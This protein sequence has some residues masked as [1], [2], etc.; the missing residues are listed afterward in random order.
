MRAILTLLIPGALA[1]TVPAAAGDI[2]ADLLVYRVEES[3]V[4]P[5]FTRYLVTAGHLRMDEGDDAGGYTLYD[6]SAGVIFNVDPEERSVLVID[7]PR[8]L[9]P[10]PLAIELAEETLPADGLAPLDGIAPARYS[11][12]ANGTACE[13]LAAVAGVMQAA[14][15]AL[16]DFDDRL[17]YQHG[18][19]VPGMPDDLVDPC[20]LARHVYAPRRAYRFG[21]PVEQR[22]ALVH[23]RL[24]DHAEGVPTDAALFAVPTGFRRLEMPAA[25]APD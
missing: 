3:G 10:A 25:P 7:P 23:R 1:G 5:Y 12:L 13:E 24:V 4:E 17:A 2:G 22:S 19:V 9:P 14:T 16:A 21:L 11:L 20:D 8:S 6:R 18:T 15:A